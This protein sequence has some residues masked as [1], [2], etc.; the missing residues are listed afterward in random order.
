MNITPSLQQRLLKDARASIQYGFESG[1]AL[2]IELVGL[3]EEIT[4]PGAAFVTLEVNSS[5]HGCIGSVE[6]YRPL[7]VDVA[8]N[9][10]SAAFEDPRFSPLTPQAMVD[11]NIQISVL[12]PAED[13]AVVSEADLLEQLVPSRDGLIL[14][15]GYHR[16]L[17]LP[18]VWEKL[19]DPASF[20]NQLKLKAGLSESYWS[21]QITCRRFT[22]ISFDEQDHTT[23]L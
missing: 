5:L 17:F 8:E 1:R 11:L 9:A 6:A 4:T 15:D 21:D 23:G 18:S 13:M 20:V 19:P 7:I 10:W 2:S 22:T 14:I 12:T 3:D 16:G